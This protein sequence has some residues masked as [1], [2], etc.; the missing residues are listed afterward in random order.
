MQEL[1]RQCT[2]CV[3]DT[4]DHEIIFDEAGVCNHCKRAQ[5]SLEDTIL[6]DD[7]EKEQKLI[8]LVQDIKEQ[9]RHKPY[10]CII[11]VSGGV[12]STYV[13][14]LVNKLGL[15]ALAVHLDN[16]WNS[17]QA[18]KNIEQTMKRLNIDLYTYVLNWEEF[19][20]LQIA[21]LKASVPHCEH[22][23]DHAITGVLYKIA[24]QKN[25]KYVLLGANISTESYGV[26]SWSGGQ[27]DWKYIKSIHKQ[28]GHIKLTNY[29]YFSGTRFFYYKFIKKIMPIN[30]INY[31]EY[32][33]EDAMKVLNDEIGWE[34]YGGKHY[35]SIFTRFFQAYILPEKFNIDKRKI[36]LSALITSKQITKQQALE[37][38][39]KPLYSSEMLQEDKEFVLKKFGFTREQFDK[40][41]NLSIKTFEDYPSYE[42]SWW[43]KLLYP[44][45]KRKQGI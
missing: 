17:E 30:I 7:K 4:S 44:L 21:F 33:K 8:K 19:K 16:G 45:F 22:P 36:H 12:D 3:M 34:Y 32:I 25:I 31:F 13:A 14:Y 2:Q 10:D 38:L 1:Y 39:K 23:T 43:F 24:A 40:I 18:V 42:N 28:F 29:P 26:K 27:R 5:Q 35:E 15:R 6:I 41:M 37:E 9:G 11:G 20:D